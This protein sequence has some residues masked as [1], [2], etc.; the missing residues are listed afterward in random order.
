MYDWSRISIPRYD[1]TVALI[2]GLVGLVLGIA[3]VVTAG[4]LPPGIDGA[5]ASK[6]GSYL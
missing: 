4:A 3:S 5:K 2:V 1:P 6:T